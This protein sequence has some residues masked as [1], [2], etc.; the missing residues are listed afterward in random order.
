[1]GNNTGISIINPF[2]TN[3]QKIPT[4]APVFLGYTYNSDD[5]VRPGNG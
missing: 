5:V 2:Y 4:A 3:K 1:M